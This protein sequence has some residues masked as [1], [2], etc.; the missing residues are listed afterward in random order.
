MLKAIT[1][2][3]FVS[4]YKRTNFEYL[5][6]KSINESIFVPTWDFLRFYVK[7]LFFRI[8]VSD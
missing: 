8:V 5:K 1:W 7:I 3:L 4:I 2:Y 6:L